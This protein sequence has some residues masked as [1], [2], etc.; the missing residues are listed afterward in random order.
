MKVLLASMDETGIPAAA[1]LAKHGF[2]TIFYTPDPYVEKKAAEYD[3]SLH[4]G[5]SKQEF[6]KLCAENKLLITRQPENSYQEVWITV[7]TI[8]EG[9]D[10]LHSA[11]NLVKTV[12]EKLLEAQRLTIAGLTKPG[13]CRHLLNLFTRSSK[14]DPSEA[15][16]IGAVSTTRNLLPAWCS[17]EKP[18]PVLEKLGAK[19]FKSPELAEMASLSKV[20]SEA[21]EAWSLAEMA[22]LYG[23]NEIVMN[24]FP[25]DVILYQE[26]LD[27]VKALKMHRNTPLL[28]NLYTRMRKTV[29]RA[30]ASVLAQVRE[31]SRKYRREFR[32][33]VVAFSET[34]GQRFVNA[35]KG[36]RVRV[37]VLDGEDVLLERLGSFTGFD[38]VLVAGLRID[39]LRELSKR[40][41]HVWFVPVV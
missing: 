9:R 27:A 34:A 15:S 39:V 38:G 33:L 20:L 3:P 41:S 32:L 11:E 10:T 17:S 21:V 14:A 1:K 12:G 22:I 36:R 23:H 26:H 18:S 16:Y 37:S 13:E 6:I 30:E 28:N 2:Q 5:I 29:Y 40:F 25:R 31:V 19:F 8:K 7:N 35:L 4:R 24:C